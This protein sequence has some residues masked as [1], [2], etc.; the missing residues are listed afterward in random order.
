MRSKSSIALSLCALGSILFSCGGTH[1]PPV[2]DASSFDV[3]AI[4]ELPA[5]VDEGTPVFDTSPSDLSGFEKDLETELPPDSNHWRSVLFPEGWTPDATLESGQ[6]L[7]DFS[8]AGYRNSESPIPTELDLPVFSISD[9]GAVEGEDAT[10]AIQSTIDAAT[11]A[12][13]GIVSI[14]EGLYRCDDLLIVSAS[15]VVLRGAGSEKSRLYFS[16]HLDMS[17]KSHIVFRGNLTT[18]PEILLVSDGEN[19]SSWL[20]VAD[21]STLLVGDD[22]AVGWEISEQFIDEHGM[23]GTWKA[24]N[25]QWVPFFRREIVAIDSSSEPHRIQLDVPIR[26]PALLRDGA[27]V[28]KES[29][30]IS[31]VGVQDLG[32]SNAVGF[33]EAWSNVRVHLVEFRGVKDGWIERLRS[34]D[35][36]LAP[37]ADDGVRKHL[38]NGGVVVR[39]SKRVSVHDTTMELAQNRGPGGCGYLFEVRTSSEILFSDCVARKGRHNF[40]QNWGFGTTGCVWLR[41]F[42]SGGLSVPL[43]AFPEIGGR[44]YSEFHH[45]LA[46]ANLIDS[47]T[48][49]DGWKAVNRQ[50]WSTGA[51]HTATQNVFWNNGG[52]GRL[53]SRQ[54]GQGYV[55][56]SEPELEIATTLTT[57]LGNKEAAGTS[58]EDYTEG[59]G[60]GETLE[61]T[62][63]FDAQLGLRI[64]EP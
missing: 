14:P 57:G 7:H 13:G 17:D 19:R 12:G 6:F 53:V 30:Y 63:L 15:N 32:L 56:G 64:Q 25:G 26:Y 54:Y 24:F 29:G 39:A 59:L 27:S 51:G 23:V 55:I 20:E 36:P 42:S 9:F 33:E 4:A 1:E 44:G 61:P 45:S 62:S 46:T 21:A 37:D 2:E 10:L 22:V 35:S 40:I 50:D 31:E 48:F 5:V 58:P 41:C 8:Y 47:C 28:K 49:N 34:F 11:E 60:L 52:T 43:Q 18:S 16:R 38:Q 3:P